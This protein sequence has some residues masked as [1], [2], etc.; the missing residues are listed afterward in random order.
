MRGSC[1]SARGVAGVAIAA[2]ILAACSGDEDPQEE[3]ADV[4]QAS[5]SSPEPTTEELVEPTTEASVDVEPTT[6]APTEEP[7]TGEPTTEDPAEPEDPEDADAWVDAGRFEFDPDPRIAGL[8]RYAIE[9][10]LAVN[11][12]DPDRPEWLATMNQVGQQNRGVVIGNDVDLGLYYPGP[13]PI[14][15]FVVG[16]EG[17]WETVTACVLAQGFALDQQDG[18]P[19]QE[20]NLVPITFYLDVVDGEY[21]YSDSLFADFSCDDVT[22]EELSW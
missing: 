2:L 6:E 13:L 17:A 22:V 4:T 7:T 8:E 15:F 1:A 9:Y 18:E 5:T 3:S 12:A 14:E 19:A 11:T 21:V 10:A 16:Q 20:R